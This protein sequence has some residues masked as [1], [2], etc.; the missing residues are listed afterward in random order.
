[1]MNNIIK[2]IDNPE[3]RTKMGKEA[4]NRVINNFDAK[5]ISGMIQDTILEVLSRS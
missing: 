4:R 2:L 3:L 1:M 5:Y